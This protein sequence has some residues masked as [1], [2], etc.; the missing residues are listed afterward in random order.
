MVN[1]KEN[2]K[3]IKKFFII[4]FLK[5]IYIYIFFFFSFLNKKKKDFPILLVEVLNIHIILMHSYKELKI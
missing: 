4:H 2:M 5:N 3:K 1:I